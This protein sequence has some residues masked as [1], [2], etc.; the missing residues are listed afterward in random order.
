MIN[1]FLSIDKDYL[2]IKRTST[3]NIFTFSDMLYKNSSFLKIKT[4]NLQ[5]IHFVEDK[6]QLVI[7]I[8]EDDIVESNGDLL[9]WGLPYDIFTGA[10]H[11][12]IGA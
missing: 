7:Y 5:N 12:K 6:E 2:V 9:D 4:N 8:S 11:V 1:L 10:P 3:N